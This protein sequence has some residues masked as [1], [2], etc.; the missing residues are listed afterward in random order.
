M[1]NIAIDTFLV[2]HKLKKRVNQQNHISKETKKYLETLPN[3]F[4]FT[5]KHGSWLNLIEAFFSKMARSFLRGIRV[6]G[7]RELIKRIELFIDEVN[8]MPVVFR[9]KYKMSEVLM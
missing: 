5:P 3:R 4:V 7:V 2:Y 9:W 8:K 1:I 6:S